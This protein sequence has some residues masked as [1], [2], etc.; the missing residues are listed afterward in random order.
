MRACL[1]TDL[2][3]FTPKF[4]LC[5]PYVFPFFDI[6][7]DHICVR[8]TVFLIE[9]ANTFICLTLQVASERESLVMHCGDYTQLNSSGFHQSVCLRL[10]K[11]SLS[12]IGFVERL[13][14]VQMLD[15]SQN[16]LRSIEG[17]YYHAIFIYPIQSVG[18]ILFSKALQISWII[19]YKN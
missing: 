1:L 11:F 15:L 18:L 2:D 14:W 7:K 5:V 9:W 19:L 3:C 17:H 13:L 12:Q 10:N 16:E 6:D 4:Y 8:A